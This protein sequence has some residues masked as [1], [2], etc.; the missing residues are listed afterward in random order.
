M[1]EPLLTATQAAQLDRGVEQALYRLLHA[2]KPFMR[3]YPQDEQAAMP[4]YDMAWMAGV[5]DDN[6]GATVIEILKAYPAL[7]LKVLPSEVCIVPRKNLASVTAQ[8]PFAAEY[9]EQSGISIVYGEAS[10][11]RHEIEFERN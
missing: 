5:G 8:H 6:P 3:A 9:L 1:A 4:E 2:L 7:W 10:R 11:L